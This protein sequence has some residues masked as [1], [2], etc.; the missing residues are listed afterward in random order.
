MPEGEGANGGQLMCASGSHSELWPADSPAVMAHITLVQGIINRLAG[1]SASCKTWCATLVAALVSLAG[2]THVPQIVSVA[3]VPV[4]IFGFLD[5]MYLAQ[6]RAYRDLYK[7]IIGK[8]RGG[9]YT[10][11]DTFDAGA[12]LRVSA[13]FSAFFSWSVW[14]VYGGLVGTYL[15]AHCMGWLVLLARPAA[16]S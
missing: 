6:E 9:K 4:V 13:C 11:T 1:N 10:L 5:T 2:A 8:V 12:P 7:R 14:P 16:G 3:L 15:T